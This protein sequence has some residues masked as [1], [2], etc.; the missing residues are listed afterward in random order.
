MALVGL[1]LYSQTAVQSGGNL[2]LVVA[3][4]AQDVL[5]HVAG[6]LHIHTVRGNHQAQPLGVLLADFHLQT[7]DYAAYCLG[8]DMLAHQAIHIGILQLHRESRSGLWAGVGYLH[9]HLGTRQFLGHQGCTLECVELG[10]GIHATLEAETCIGTE[11]MTACTLAN[12]SGVE[13]GTLEQDI[14]GG[15]VGAAALAAQHTGY[16]HGLLGVADGQVAV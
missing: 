4:Y 1:A 12:P 13:I 11:A 9:A 6:A 10:I 7:G 3:V 8:R 2:H 5:H 14:L 16:T 15:V